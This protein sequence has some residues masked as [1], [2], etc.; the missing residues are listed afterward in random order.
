MMLFIALSFNKRAAP[1][2]DARTLR[3]LRAYLRP[4]NHHQTAPR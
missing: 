2:I 4:Q 1:V 3:L